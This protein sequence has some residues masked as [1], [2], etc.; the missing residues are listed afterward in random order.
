[1]SFVMDFLRVHGPTT[2]L[3][4]VAALVDVALGSLAATQVLVVVQVATGVIVV[5]GHLFMIVKSDRL[6]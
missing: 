2:L 6:R 5:T 3:A 4:L 1:M